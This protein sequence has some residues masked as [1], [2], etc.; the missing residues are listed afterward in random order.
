[1]DMHEFGAGSERLI[2]L[3]RPDDVRSDVKPFGHLRG[4]RS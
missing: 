2:V 1:M 3:Y 4:G